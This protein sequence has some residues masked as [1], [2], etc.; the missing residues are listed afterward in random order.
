MRRLIFSA[1][2]LFFASS[3]SAGENLSNADILQMVSLGLSDEIIVAKIK[4]SENH[5]D[6]SS[7]ALKNLQNNQVSTPVIAA[8]ISAESQPA[9]SKPASAP[10][11]EGDY[12]EL[13][14]AGMVINLEEVR[15]RAEGSQ[16]KQWIPIYGKFAKPETFVFLAGAHADRRVNQGSFTIMTTIPEKR[17]RLV[18]LDRHKRSG[19]RFAVFADGRSP[20]EIN[21]ITKQRAVNGMLEIEPADELKSGEYALLVTPEITRGS[22]AA[23]IMGVA[24]EQAMA[25][26]FMGAS[27]FDFQI[28]AA[29]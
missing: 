4:N 26:N 16:R 18:Q 25:N 23:G 5:F 1:F 21:L 9:E 11:P 14:A 15:V 22:R 27:A 13:R 12:V 8:M 10:S 19:D 29:K 20:R 3:A 2:L 17:I 28:I 6:T 7:T 24:M